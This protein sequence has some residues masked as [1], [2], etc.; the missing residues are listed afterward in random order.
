MKFC[1]RNKKTILSDKCQDKRRKKRSI[2][3][4]VFSVLIHVIL[5]YLFF[6]QDFYKKL[7]VLQKKLQEKKLFVAKRPELPASLKPRK[8]RFGTTVFF[9]EPEKKVPDSFPKACTKET[10]K[11]LKKELKKK[12]VKQKIKPVKRDLKRV[13]KRPVKQK[14]KPKRKIL[15]SKRFAKKSRFKARLEKKQKVISEKRVPQK[16]IT[17]KKVQDVREIKKKI[18]ER[19]KEIEKK[20]AQIAQEQAQE[21]VR[22]RDAH[23]SHVIRPRKK[24]IPQKKSIIALTKGFLENQVQKG[25]DWLERKGDDNK[26]PSFEELKYLSYEQRVNWQLQAAW[27]Q[28]YQHKM[29]DPAM[30]GKAVVDFVLNENGD[31]L[32]LNL[33]QSSGKKELDDIILENIRRAAPFAPLPKHFGSKTYATGRVIRVCSSRFGF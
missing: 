32:S 13:I 9:E 5:L 33:L 26:R 18:T 7:S 27:K 28:C 12:I 23:A 10:R 29:L 8:S 30:Q 17:E 3:F 25:D 19:I 6:N 20:Q 11:E 1:N 16:T 22:E 14:L 31:L 2:F 24:Q 15:P 21:Q 4:I